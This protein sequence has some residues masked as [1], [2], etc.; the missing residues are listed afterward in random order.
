MQRLINLQNAYNSATATEIESL[1][2]IK[3]LEED[4]IEL[5]KKR[6]QASK[7]ASNGS[8]KVENIATAERNL[9][10]AI[11]DKEKARLAV[12]KARLDRALANEEIRT[13]ITAFGTGIGQDFDLK[14][15]QITSSS[16]MMQEANLLEEKK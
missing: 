9:Q 14:E 6:E 11:I 15:Q 4:I 12:E 16:L 13:I 5:K 2:R 1:L 7:D 3:Q 8:A 10:E